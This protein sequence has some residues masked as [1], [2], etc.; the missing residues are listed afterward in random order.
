[1]K[2]KHAPTLKEYC[3]NKCSNTYKFPCSIEKRHIKNKCVE[4]KDYTGAKL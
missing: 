1:M 3:N 2:K 4:L